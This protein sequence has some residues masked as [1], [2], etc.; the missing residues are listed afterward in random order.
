MEHNLLNRI[1]KRHQTRMAG[2]CTA[3]HLKWAALGELYRWK[4]KEQYSLKEWGETVSYLLGC[5]VQFESYEQIAK[6]LK[7]FAL[8]VR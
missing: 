5:D 8:K 1:A 4:N 2:L 3:P 6:S 7:P